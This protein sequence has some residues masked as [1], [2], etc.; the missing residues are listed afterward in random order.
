MFAN[1][2]ADL[3]SCPYNGTNFIIPLSVDPKIYE[4]FLPA[5][6]HKVFATGHSVVAYHL[7]LIFFFFTGYRVIDNVQ[8][9]GDRQVRI[10]QTRGVPVD[11]NRCCCYR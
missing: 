7:P 3:T 1:Y 9:S 11:R 8:P 10:L 2:L 5:Y 4:I 6:T